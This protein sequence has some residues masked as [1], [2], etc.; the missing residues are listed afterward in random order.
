MLARCCVLSVYGTDGVLTTT[1][2]GRDDVA[3]SAKRIQLPCE[4]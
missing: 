4:P 1:G 3:T 2:Q